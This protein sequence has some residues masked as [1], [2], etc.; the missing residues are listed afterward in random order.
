VVVDDQRGREFVSALGD[1]LAGQAT[2][3]MLSEGIRNG[4]EDA[5]ARIKANASIEVVLEGNEVGPARLPACSRPPALPLS[6]MPA[7]T[8]KCSVRRP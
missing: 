8:R 3:R 4:F 1:S 5:A 7:S 6:R 2:H